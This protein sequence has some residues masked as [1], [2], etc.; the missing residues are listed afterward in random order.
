MA[1]SLN[2]PTTQIGIS[3]NNVYF[4]IATLVVSYQR[5][6]S[7]RFM[8]DL[9]GY[10]TTTP[11]PDTR[12]VDFKRLHGNYPDLTAQTGDNEIAKAYA[13]CMAQPE[14]EGSTAI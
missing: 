14:F 7:R 6:G 8:V 4:R 3:L 2:L 11:D 12:D 10:A 1:I 9:V 13:W 5:D